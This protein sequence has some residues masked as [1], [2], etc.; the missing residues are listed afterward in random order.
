MSRKQREQPPTTLH[1]DFAGAR[2]FLHRLTQPV[3]AR[4]AVIIPL[5]LWCHRC[6]VRGQDLSF[7][8]KHNGTES[9]D[10]TDGL[11]AG[12]VTYMVSTVDL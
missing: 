12:N 3:L 2:C 9:V 1:P 4:R 6:Q 8:K 5:L 11:H 10:E 7:F